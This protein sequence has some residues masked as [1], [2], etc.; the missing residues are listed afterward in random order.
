MLKRL[1]HELDYSLSR[2]D[3]DVLMLAVQMLH[4]SF[5]CP[6]NVCLEAVQPSLDDRVALAFKLLAEGF[7]PEPLIDRGLVDPGAPARLFGRR[8]GE[9]VCDHA[10]LPIR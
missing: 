4:Q 10:P 9:Q 1:L 8:G 7:L 2:T 3:T 6:G 5:G